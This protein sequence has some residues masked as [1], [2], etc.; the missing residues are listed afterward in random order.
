MDITDI[1]HSPL[2]KVGPWPQSLLDDIHLFLANVGGNGYDNVLINGDFD[3]FQRGPGFSL[4]P[5]TTGYTLDRWRLAQG[6]GCTVS[7][8][9]SILGSVSYNALTT[10]WQ[11][12]ALAFVGMSV[13]P[14]ASTISQRI[15]FA[16]TLAGKTATLSFYAA[17]FNGINNNPLALTAS[18]V[19]NFGSAGGASAP[20][21]TPIT[22]FS[23]PHRT[24]ALDLARYEWTFDIPS[25][26]GKAFGTPA[27][28]PDSYLE[29][30]LSLPAGPLGQLYLGGMDLRAGSFAIP[31]TPI[32]M[33]VSL[34][35]CQRFYQKSYN[36]WVKPG[37]GPDFNGARNMRV[38]AAS[39]TIDDPFTLHGPMRST[40]ALT[41]YSPNSGTA[42]RLYNNTTAADMTVNN[43]SAGGDSSLGLIVLSAAPAAADRLRL[44][45]TADAEL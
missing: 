39:A 5:A 35:R 26:V 22:V 41:I 8:D 6:A 43:T 20:V 19:Q 33:D 31:Y 30:V 29:L 12:R 15:E 36:Q 37:A 7:L 4:A 16:T 38:V 13:T 24:A 42:A 3:I 14:A 18:V 21:T 44:H 45:Y 40:P 1:P 28:A 27:T 34:T 2:P 11:P 10:P 32:P 25:I 9:Q 17:W 23:I